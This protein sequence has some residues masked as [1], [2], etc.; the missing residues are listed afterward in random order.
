MKKFLLALF[1]LALLTAFTAPAD[2]AE[3]KMMKKPAMKK[4]AMKKKAPAGPT[5]KMQGW[6]RVRGVSQ[7]NADY[8]EDADD[9]SNKLDALLRPRFTT[10]AG[11]VRLWWEPQFSAFAGAEKRAVVTNRWVLEFAIPGSALK[12]RLGK[13]DSAS[14]DGEVYKGSGNRIAGVQVFGKLSKNLSLSMFHNKSEEDGGHGNDDVADYYAGLAINVAPNLTLTPWAANSRNGADG[15]YNYSFLGL[16]AKGKAGIFSVNASGVFQSGE[17]GDGRDVSA[18]A[19]LLRAST[20]LGKLKLGGNVTMLSGDDGSD[21]SESGKFTGPRNGAGTEWAG[22]YIASGGGGETAL[23]M[24]LAGGGS[25][26]NLNGAVVLEGLASYAVSKTLTLSGSVAVYNSAESSGGMGEDTAKDFGTQV[27]V[28]MKWQIH[29][30]LSLAA[31]AA[32][33][34]RG[35]YGR[36]ADGPDPDDAWLVGWAVVHTF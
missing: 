24:K 28:S 32:V 11:G 2:A 20:S 15:G 9:K 21:T 17:L 36:A 16:N 4:P 1:A 34:M 26:S 25:F 22:K 30:S 18:W 10:V 6:Y 27:G 14:A 12:M 7:N 29:P 8:D 35:D 19:L 33:F 23:T 5:F 13:T 3:K 31:D